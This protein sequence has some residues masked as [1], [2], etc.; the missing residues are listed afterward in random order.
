MNTITN[1]IHIEQP[2]LRGG[3][4][5]DQAKSVMI[6]LHGRGA[7]A[8]DIMSLANEFPQD[9]RAFLAPQAADYTWYPFRFIEPIEHNEPWLSSALEKVNRLMKQSENA[10]IPASKIIL[11]GFSQ[12]ACLALEYAVRNARRFGGII[13]FSGGLIGPPG[14]LWDFPGSLEKT[15]VFLGCDQNDFHI[16][17]ERVEETARILSSRQAE[18]TMEFY[19]DL[20]HSINM[21]EIQTSRALIG[22]L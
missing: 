6:L 1:Q 5:L 14:T 20:G 2:V 19:P 13:G 18:V 8:E 4:S 21:D 16:P 10:G 12:G 15:P 3:V 7:S 22:D 9:R 11:A 17:R